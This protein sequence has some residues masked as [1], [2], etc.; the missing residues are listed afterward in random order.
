M[1]NIDAVLVSVVSAAIAAMGL[2]LSAWSHRTANRA[3]TKA[4]ERDSREV[5]VYLHDAFARHS[6]ARG[7]LHRAF[8]QYGAEWW[9]KGP[10]AARLQRNGRINTAI[11][12]L[13]MMAIHVELGYIERAVAQRFWGMAAASCWFKALDFIEH[14][15]GQGFPEHWA[16]LERFVEDVPDSIRG[17][18]LLNARLNDPQVPTAV[19]NSKDVGT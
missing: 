12:E 13:N 8:Q 4:M 2:I 14:R 5:L 3:L 11:A 18:S 17:S 15:R 1:E 19:E 9:T 6:A 7:E 10:E 16:E